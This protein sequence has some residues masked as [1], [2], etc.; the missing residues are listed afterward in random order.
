M[1]GMIIK[2]A[3]L[4]LPCGTIALG[5]I[6]IKDGKINT[7]FLDD[8]IE[9]SSGYH[10]IDAQ[11][12]YLSAGFI[13]I[14]VHGG[15]GF[16]F[17][18]CNLEEY[19]HIADVHARY[20]TTSMLPTSLTS[21]PEH[22]T[23][24][25]ETYR[26]FMKN[27]AFR[28]RFLGLHLE[29]PYFALNQRGAQDPKY[30]RDPD[31][32]EY[33]PILQKYAPLIARWSAAPELNGALAFGKELLKFGII[34]SLAHTD[35]LYEDI[36]RGLDA[37]YKLATH[38]YS[39][40]SGMVRKDAFRY[41]GAIESC[42]LLDEITAEIIADGVHLPEPFLKLIVKVKTVD[43]IVLVTDAMR[44]AGTK[45]TCSKLG[46]RKDGL[47]VI[48]EQEVAKLPD[49]SSFAGSVATADRLVR[50]MVNVAGV[51]LPDAVKM[52]TINP[53]QVIG[54]DHMLGSISVGKIANVILF[55][56]DI[57]VKLT[58]V[59]GNVIYRNSI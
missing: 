1:L 23:V 46:D 31:P 19:Q 14:H 22:L 7:I 5:G 53:A 25:L 38:L 32:N 59:E 40:M 41:A 3:K 48:I 17:M 43:R 4:I 12:L 54:V 24:L 50:T 39:G 10:V 44:A 55:D 57:R 13:D 2:N 45:D 36:L 8:M 9:R 42:L 27:G 28:S 34:P 29:G 15:G 47:N 18:D 35:A 16:D 49:R 52:L 58:V 21:N 37:G 6:V 30:I 56:K 26:S 20:G 11:G 51:T 33:M